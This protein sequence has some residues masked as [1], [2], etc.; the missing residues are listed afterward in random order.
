METHRVVT[1][2]LQT[3]HGRFSHYD[4]TACGRQ[5]ASSSQCATVCVR[6]LPKAKDK[7][8]GST[9]DKFGTRHVLI[10]QGVCERERE[11]ACECVCEREGDYFNVCVSTYIYIYVCVCVCVCV[12]L[13]CVWRVHA[14]V[15]VVF[16]SKASA[17][18][19]VWIS[20]PAA[21]ACACQNVIVPHLYLR[22]ASLLMLNRCQACP[23]CLDPRS[24]LS[25]TNHQGMAY[26][27]ALH[28]GIKLNF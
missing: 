20:S 24:P 21:C 9:L 26:K 11:R 22:L 12:C 27:S 23:T 2:G 7:N 6:T 3:C 5:A 14:Y 17:D 1:Q 15:Y 16:I 19:V 25:A 8:A 4:C 10:S 28:L 18:I 13:V